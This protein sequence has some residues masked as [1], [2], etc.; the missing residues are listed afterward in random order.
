MDKIFHGLNEVAYM[1]GIS[2]RTVDRLVKRKELKISWIGGVRKIH[3]EDFERFVKRVR[4]Q[5]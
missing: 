4:K 5:S 3:R 1:L 2:P